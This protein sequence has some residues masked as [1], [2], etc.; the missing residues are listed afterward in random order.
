MKKYDKIKRLGHAENDSIFDYPDDELMISEK[1]DGSNAR[2]MVEDNEIVFGSRNVNNLDRDNKQ[3]KKFINYILDNIKPE[4]LDPDYIYVGEFMVSHTLQYDWDNIPTFIGFDILVKETGKPINWKTSK[5]LF[6]ELGL[7]FVPVLWEGTVREYEEVELPEYESK[8]RDG[9]PEG[10]V[11]KNYSRVNMY[12]RPLFAKVVH[13]HFQEKKSTYQPKN[14]VS[15]NTSRVVSE[16][17]T[18]ARIRKII[19][20]MVVE[21][22]KELSRS[23]MNSLIHRVINDTLQEEIVDIKN[24]K[25]IDKVDFKIL[26]KLVPEKC[27]FVIDKMMEE[28]VSK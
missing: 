6:E 14:A 9:K 26:Y 22:G 11:I 23:L 25:H 13:E 21:E 12:G 20:K 10:V 2:F 7:E 16:Y 8:Y 28:K 17:V 3:F 24:N 4:Q 1:M 27:L 15:K 5:R 19:N 18:K